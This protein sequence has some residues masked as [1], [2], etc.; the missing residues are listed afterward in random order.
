MHSALLPL[1]CKLD[2][3]WWENI[4]CIFYWNIVL[5]SE[6]F[7]PF[8]VKSGLGFCW[9]LLSVFFFSTAYWKIW[10]D[11]FFSSL[12]MLKT[13]INLNEKFRPICFNFWMCWKMKPQWTI[14]NAVFASACSHFSSNVADVMDVRVY[15]IYSVC[16]KENKQNGTLCQKTKSKKQRRWEKK[17]CNL[18]LFFP[19]IMFV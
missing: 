6:E 11:E 8:I 10:I 9:I 19:F 16:S 17:C 5:N 1:Y 14:K 7:V 18:A 13:S 15:I 4:W 3:G 2:Y 12:K